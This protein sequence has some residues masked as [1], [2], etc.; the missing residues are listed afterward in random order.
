MQELGDREPFFLAFS[1]GNKMLKYVYSSS[2]VPVFGFAVVYWLFCAG[3]TCRHK[4][5]ASFCYQTDVSK[6]EILTTLL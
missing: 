1:V 2:D 3:F 4:P 6:W 5:G